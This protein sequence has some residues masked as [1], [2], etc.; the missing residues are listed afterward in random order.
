MI[1]PFPKKLTFLLGDAGEIAKGHGSRIYRL[2][3]YL[4]NHAANLVFRFENDAVWW[5][6]VFGS[7]WGVGG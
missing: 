6:G 1:D 2:C 4:V 3:S 5:L 7:R